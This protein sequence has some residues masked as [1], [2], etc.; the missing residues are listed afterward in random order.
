MPTCSD[1]CLHHRCLGVIIFTLGGDSVKSTLKS[2]HETPNLLQ[3]WNWEENDKSGYSPML[4][5]LGSNK[6]VWWKCSQG[7]SYQSTPNNRAAGKGCPYCSGRKALPGVNDLATVNPELAAE[8][9]YERNSDFRIEEVL[10]FSNKKVS[11]KCKTCGFMWQATVN[12]NA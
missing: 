7:H 12:I 8:W 1:K 6:R 2:V 3:E 5:T 11:W 4:I 10:P 9:D